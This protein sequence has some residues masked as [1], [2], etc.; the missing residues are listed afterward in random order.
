MGEYSKAID[1]LNEY[2]NVLIVD[3]PYELD[4]DGYEYE[5]AMVGLYEPEGDK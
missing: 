1:E 3:F 5:D 4:I 2:C